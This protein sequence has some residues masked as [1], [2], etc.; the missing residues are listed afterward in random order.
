MKKKDA[1]V[2]MC[3]S[4]LLCALGIIIPMF[5]PKI[6]IPPMSFT[7]ASHVPIFIAMFI[8]PASAIM[9]T[10]VTTIGFALSMPLVVALRAASQIVFV[11]VGAFLLKK[12][13]SLLQS[14]R[15]ATPFAL[16]LAVLHGACEAIVVTAFYF[17][18]N[19]SE[20]WYESGYVV[21][22]LLLVGLGT[23]VHSMVDFGI[24]VAVWKPLC[25]MLHIP[26]SAKMRMRTA[27]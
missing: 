14:A 20:S 7:L 26:V 6:W 9:V 2:S 17:T 15:T 19:G 11:L 13:G 16:L 5:M 23:L 4:A 12:S 27:S 3:I 1:V 8:S 25:P 22:V 18:G 24:A 10:V 21:S